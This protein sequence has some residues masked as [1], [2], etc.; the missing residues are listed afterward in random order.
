MFYRGGVE[1]LCE[2]IAQLVVDNPKAPPGAKTWSSAN[3]NPAIADFVSL[4]A[5]LPPSDPR[6]SALT[7]ALQ[8]HFMSAKQ[9]VN[10]TAALQSTFT[11]A[12]MSPSAVSIGL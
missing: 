1:N 12:C 9:Q 4:V 3:P 2:S 5:A 11:M 7:S 10:A 6:A 8:A